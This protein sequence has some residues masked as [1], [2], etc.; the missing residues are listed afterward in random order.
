MYTIATATPRARG[1]FMLLAI[2]RLFYLRWPL[3][4]E[5]KQDLSSGKSECLCLGQSGMRHYG[6]F[7][8]MIETLGARLS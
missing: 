1:A 5:E 3:S 4:R 7:M 8:Q 6:P 2:F